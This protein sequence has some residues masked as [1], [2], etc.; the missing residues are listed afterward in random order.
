MGSQTPHYSTDHGAERGIAVELRALSKRLTE[1][2]GL[3]EAHLAMAVEALENRDTELAGKIITADA[4]I[5]AIETEINAQAM[6]LLTRHA[7]VAADLREIVAAL[8]IS[9]NVERIGDYVAN[10]AKRTIV[11]QSFSGVPALAGVIE[12]ARLVRMYVQNVFD[13][14]SERDVAKAEAVW[15][16]D[17]DIDAL[18]TSVFQELLSDMLSDSDH[19]PTCTHLLFC[20]KSLE[21]IGDHATNIAETIQFLVA[22]K[23]L[24]ERRPKQNAAT[25]FELPFPHPPTA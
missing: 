21:R 25:G 3:A 17:A 24:A 6:A 16:G 23:A 1:M 18:H 5:D 13:A 14:Y 20:I 2:S 19:V 7:P 9:S 11:I 10:V 15:R 22:G 4:A 12:M 8:K